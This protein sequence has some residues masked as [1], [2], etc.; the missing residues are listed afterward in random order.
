MRA[1]SKYRVPFLR[2][3]VIEEHAEML[4]GEWALEYPPIA[5]PPVP[6]EDI[7]E[8]GLKLDFEIA[9]LRTELGHDDVLG[10]IWFGARLVKVDQSLDPTNNTRLLGRYRFTIAH[11]IGH[12]RLH[13]EHLMNDPSAASLFDQTD[14]PAFVCRSNSKPPEEW[15]ADQFAACILMPH[16][17]VFE[18]W[19]KWRGDRDQVALTELNIDP[20]DEIALDAFCRPLADLFEVSAQAMRIRLQGLELLVKEKE[21]RLF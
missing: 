20:D 13:R 19:E 3:K 11:E 14:T 17:L 12:W 5:E 10:G 18:A 15:Q 21:P 9:D 16:S 2:E 7:L 8:F 4:L 6:I 1:P